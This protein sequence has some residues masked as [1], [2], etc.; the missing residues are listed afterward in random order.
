MLVMAPL[1]PD[2]MSNRLLRIRHRTNKITVPQ[3]GPEEITSDRLLAYQAWPNHIHDPCILFS[4]VYMHTSTVL[5]VTRIS[6]LTL[7]VS[8]QSLG[9]FENLRQNTRNLFA[10]MSSVRCTLCPFYLLSIDWSFRNRCPGHVLIWFEF[11]ILFRVGLAASDRK[12]FTENAQAQC[13]KGA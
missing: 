8:R 12:I 9:V 2:P 4:L 1:S 6:K 7:P 10:Y 11:W 5:I 3:L 13:A